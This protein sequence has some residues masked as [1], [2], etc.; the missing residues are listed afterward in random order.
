MVGG[1]A[2]SEQPVPPFAPVPL[3]AEGRVLKTQN[4]LGILD[5]SSSMD[6]NYGPHKKFDIATAVVRNIADTLPENKGLKSGLRIFGGDAVCIYPIQ[7]GDDPGGKE[8]LDEIAKI[9]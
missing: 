2:T 3:D 9:D 6:E 4:V 5:A 8:L 7:V 1:C